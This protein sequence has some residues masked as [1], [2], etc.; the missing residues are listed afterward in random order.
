MERMLNITR[1]QELVGIVWEE[2]FTTDAKMP[3][4]TIVQVWRNN[5]QMLNK[6]I[7]H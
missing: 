1:S 3:Q 5:Q 2:V 7:T 4:D 6:V